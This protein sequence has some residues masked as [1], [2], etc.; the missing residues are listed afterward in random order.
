M[1]GRFDPALGASEQWCA[2]HLL[3]RLHSYTPE[4]AA[5]RNRTGQ[6]AGFHE[7][8]P[9]LA[10]RGP[11]HPPPGPGRAVVGG[12]AAAGLRARGRRLGGVRPPGPGRGL[13]AA[14]AGRPLPF[15]RGRAGAGCRCA[16]PKRTASPGGV[17]PRRRAPP[18]SPSPSAADLPWLTMATR[19][20]RLA[21]GT[22]PR[23]GPRRAR[24]PPGA[25]GDVL[26]GPARRNAAASP[27]RC[28]RAC[29]TWSPGAS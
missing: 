2:R 12:R 24:R 7:V 5:A 17:P 19:G 25:R 16:R 3:A 27:S 11:R 26:L 1:R 20:E 8:P 23:S 9:A 28:R 6:L 10:A 29:G 15:G 21:R 22:C 18:P 14:L 13:P 4:P